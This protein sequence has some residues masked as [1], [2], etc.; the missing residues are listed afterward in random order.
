[1]SDTPRHH[2]NQEPADFAAA[3]E[4]LRLARNDLASITRE[5]AFCKAAHAEL[6]RLAGG[7]PLPGME[8][9]EL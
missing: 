9:G 3:V 7:P 6:V 4:L 8:K 1:M 2:L 5:L